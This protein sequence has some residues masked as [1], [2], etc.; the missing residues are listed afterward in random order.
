[1]IV[2]KFEL[3]SEAHA[4]R[5]S[6]QSIGPTGIEMSLSITSSELLEGVV[7]VGHNFLGARAQYPLLPG[8]FNRSLEKNVGHIHPIRPMYHNHHYLSINSLE[9]SH[10]TRVSMQI[11]HMI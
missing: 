2:H 3:R 5:D 1:M 11:L 8:L 6:E 9:L 7:D 4:S 10:I